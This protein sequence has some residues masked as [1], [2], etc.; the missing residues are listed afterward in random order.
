MMDG[1]RTMLSAD[2]FSVAMDVVLIVVLVAMW[3]LWWKQSKRTQ[4]VETGLLE[5][6]SQL[7]E[8]TA[9]L[10]D[11]L[12]QISLLQ[13][14]EQS[15]ASKE[16]QIKTERAV[17]KPVLED[18]FDDDIEPHFSSRSREL[19]DAQRNRSELSVS[20][21]PV[22][23]NHAQNSSSESKQ[24]VMDVAKILRMQREGAS[25]DSIADTL[26]MPLAQVKLMLMLQKGV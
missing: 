20:H 4:R 24:G 25:L 3:M 8:A 9:L 16:T 21:V 26:N 14:N 12:N 22:K 5:A 6:A 19:L 7:Q 18:D 2:E 23:N 13:Q 10:D 11:A 17:T 15:K 1:W